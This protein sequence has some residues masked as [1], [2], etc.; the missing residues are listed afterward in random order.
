MTHTQTHVLERDSQHT[1]YCMIWSSCERRRHKED[2]RG[3]LCQ[4]NDKS[5][6]FPTFTLKSS[7]QAV[8]LK[9]SKTTRERKNDFSRSFQRNVDWNMNLASTEGANN[10]T[11]RHLVWLQWTNV[12]SHRQ[13]WRKCAKRQLFQ[14]PPEWSSHKRV[15]FACASRQSPR[16]EMRERRRCE[17]EKFGDFS[18]S[19]RENY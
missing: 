12:F 15:V 5:F 2:V 10:V 6:A 17:R 9:S 11:S 19:L 13:S 3:I 7:R 8:F 14:T 18:K 16:E 1:M 4:F